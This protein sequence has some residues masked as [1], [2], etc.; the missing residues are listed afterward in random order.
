MQFEPEHTGNLQR[1]FVEEILPSLKLVKGCL[2]SRKN[3]FVLIH[4]CNMICINA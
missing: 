4:I 3:G 2:W 1:Y